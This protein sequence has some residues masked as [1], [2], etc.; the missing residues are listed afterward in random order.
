MTGTSPASGIQLRAVLCLAR[1]DHAA[2]A[3]TRRVLE[4][5]LLAIGVSDECRG[6]LSI[7]VTEAC[8]NAITHADGCD[9]YQ[10]TVIVHGDQ[11]MVEVAD[12][13]VGLAGDAITA[14][15]P[16]LNAEGGRG[17]HVIR[18]CTDRME[19]RAVRPHGVAIRMIKTLVWTAAPQRVR[20]MPACRS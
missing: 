8:T 20:A 16:A 5:A 12:T 15:L 1:A 2:V 3:V 9:D 19:L 7:A 18:A 6:D 4:A 11:L 14:E 13:G 10:V 17:L